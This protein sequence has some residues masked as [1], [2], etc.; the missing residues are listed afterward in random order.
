V[1]GRAGGGGG[2]VSGGERTQQVQLTLTS[3]IQNT[4]MHTYS[5]RYTETHTTDTYICACN[6]TASPAPTSHPR[7]QPY[8]AQHACHAGSWRAV[9]DAPP[10]QAVDEGALADVG[11]PYD[12]G[13]HGAGLQ[14]PA[15]A[16]VIDGLA[17]L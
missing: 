17:G 8:P 16:L 12:A 13:A 11:E 7:T 1:S 10:Q 15:G 14:P 6:H 5:H 4:T 2:M 9:H 3:Y